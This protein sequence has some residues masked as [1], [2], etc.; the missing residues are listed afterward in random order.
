MDEFLILPITRGFGL[1]SESQLLAWA[2]AEAVE[3][4][5]CPEPVEIECDEWLEVTGVDARRIPELTLAGTL[6]GAKEASVIVIEK[7][8]PGMCSSS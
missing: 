8:L 2:W 1:A 7:G 5:L 3:L 6:G 4:I